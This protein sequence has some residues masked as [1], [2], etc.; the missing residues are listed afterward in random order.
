M[1]DKNP[2]IVDR[3]LKEIDFVLGSA[4]EMSRD[5]FMLDTYA[6]HAFAMALL[7]IGELA[8]RLDDSYRSDHGSVPWEQMI[9]FR[10]AA[11]H[12]YDG[13][14]MEIVWNTVEKDLPALKDKLN[15]LL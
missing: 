10:N 9:G 14:D 12:G 8:K 6:Q 11:A 7:N 4:R 1:D 15:S 5:N 3:I 13:L 2:F